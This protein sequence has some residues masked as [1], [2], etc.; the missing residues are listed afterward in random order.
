MFLENL[1]YTNYGSL[2]PDPNPM[3]RIDGSV[4]RGKTIKLF[5]INISPVFTS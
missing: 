4:I 5:Q 1:S 2:P 3:T